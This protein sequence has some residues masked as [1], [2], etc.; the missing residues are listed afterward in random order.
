MESAEAEAEADPSGVVSAAAAA[1]ATATS[2]WLRDL[3][4]EREMMTLEGDM[5]HTRGASRREEA[6]EFES[7]L[8]SAAVPPAP[9][10]SI[11]SRLA[12]VSAVRSDARQALLASLTCSSSYE[13]EAGGDEREERPGGERG[14]SG[15]AAQARFLRRL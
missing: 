14:N 1:C 6:Y 5:L 15:R 3:A 2:I 9:L 11:S 10:H 13:G 4:A 8:S 12:L 7:A